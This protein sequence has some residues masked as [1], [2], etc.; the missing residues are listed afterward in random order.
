MHTDLRNGD[1]AMLAQVLK[2]QDA[3]KLDVIAPAGK[4]RADGTTIVV[5]DAITDL[6]ID[7]VTSRPARLEPT[8]VFD[9]GVSEK[10][11]IPLAYVRR[12]R[13]ARPDLYAANVNGWL[14]GDG[15]DTGPDGRSFM[16]RAFTS[17]DGGIARALLSDSYKV[18]DNIDVLT[19]SLDGIRKAGVEAEV[20]RCDL[21]ERR[22]YVKVTAPQVLAY[23]PE[24][25]A[26]YRSPFTGQSGTDNPAV[27]AGFIVQNSEVGGGAFSITPSLTIQ[28][29]NNGLTI[30]KDVM[31]AVHLGSRLE[32]GV[33]RWSEE[34]QAKTL[35]LVT[36]KATDAVRTFLD[37]E[38]VKAQ[39]RA[40]EEKAGVPITGKVQ[41]VV[42]LVA[43]K[44]LFTEET[45]E[46]VL[47]HFLRAGQFTAGGVLHAVTSYAQTVENADDA[48]ALEEAGLRA[49]EVAAAL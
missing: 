38:Y 19:A 15:G 27:F 30:T 17:E 28:V 40:L 9:E 33:I 10:L 24:L 25:L 1:L 43:K 42:R 20:A 23:A 47:D 13:E 31:R 2:E 45:T 14:H 6:S 22:M 4:I 18:M 36:L 29:C 49:L 7:G 34:T 48:Y 37:V 12:M 5:E 39:I 41:D 46:G 26:G 16:V 32:E 3:A 11:S 8:R 21:T 44:C 35:E